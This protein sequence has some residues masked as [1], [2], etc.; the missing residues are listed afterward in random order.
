MTMTPTAPNRSSPTRVWQ[1]QQTSWVLGGRSNTL[2]I[3]PVL[4]YI[5][6]SKPPEPIILEALGLEAI[7]EYR[8]IRRLHDRAAIPALDRPELGDVSV[9]VR[10]ALEF[11]RTHNGFGWAMDCARRKTN[12][13]SARP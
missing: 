11:S 1:G 2:M 8:K 9:A 3:L 12:G 7:T 10:P 6:L 4:G 5:A 13:D